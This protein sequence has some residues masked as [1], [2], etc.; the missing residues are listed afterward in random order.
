MA[1]SVPWKFCNDDK[2]C[3]HG[4]RTIPIMVAKRFCPSK[5]WMDEIANATVQAIIAL[6]YGLVGIPRS[7]LMVRRYLRLIKFIPGIN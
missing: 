4:G 2:Y 7:W 1:H 3:H 6:M 5:E